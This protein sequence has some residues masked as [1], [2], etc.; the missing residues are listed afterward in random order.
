MKKILITGGAGFIGSHLVDFFLNKNYFVTVFDKYNSQNNWGWLEPLKKNKKLFVKL[1][2]I[3]DYDLLND[4][5]KENSQV[6]HL[7]A[8]IGIPYSYE[9][10]LAYIRTNIEGTYNVLESCRKNKSKNLIITSTSEVYGSSEYE[11]MNELHP[12][13]S[14]SP[15]AAS[16]KSADELSLSYYKSFNSNIKIIRPFNTFGPRQSARAIIPSIIFQL[17]N[18]KI[19]YVKLGNTL[20]KRDYTYV[21]DTCEAYY[22]LLKLNNFGEIFNVGT[23]IN[24][25]IE[26]IYKK[27][28]TILGIKK[29]IKIEKKR[30][31][32][33]NSE[34]ISLMCDYK[35]L[36]KYTGWKPT[37][38]FEKGLI[39]TAVWIKKNINIY[40]DI[41]NT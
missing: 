5:I 29:K 1:G 25:S 34:V 15:Y 4:L 27:I 19:E 11:P 40:K 14:Q 41:Y 32:K 17:L 37:I 16:K 31:R 33:S 21:S 22:N 23:G 36:N 9:S 7:A 18:K 12:C 10:P 13:K 28:S 24:Y 26:E 38:K 20:P 3:R 2:D 6:I 30:I 8:L 39:K 35:K